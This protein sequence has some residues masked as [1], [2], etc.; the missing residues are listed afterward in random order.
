MK[1]CIIL[2]C[3]L[4]LSTRVNSR[5]SKN[6]GV[7]HNNSL[8]SN[9]EVISSLLA[10]RDLGLAHLAST[11]MT[12]KFQASNMDIAFYFKAVMGF[13]HGG[14]VVE[15]NILLDFI[16][17]SFLQPDGDVVSPGLGPG[18]KSSNGMYNQFYGYINGWLCREAMRTGRMDIHKPAW[19]FYRKFQHPL[20]GGQVTGGIFKG[21]ETDITDIFSTAN[22]GLTALE[23]GDFDAAAKA[24]KYIIRAVSLQPN[25]DEFFYLKQTTEGELITEG[26]PEEQY[27]VYYL[28]TDQPDQLWFMLGYPLVLLA[29]MGQVDNNKVC[30][31]TADKILDF[32]D[33][34]SDQRFASFWSHKIALGTSYMAAV[35]KDERYVKTSQKIV[36]E[37]MKLQD[38][39]G[40]FSYPG[41]TYRDQIDQTA[42]VSTWWSEI[43]ANLA[44][45]KYSNAQN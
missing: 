14:R 35:W 3:L 18:E 9:D 37:L 26:F 41:M 19:D 7:D 42:E 10:S 17:A 28:R 34:C 23:M 32:F 40:L 36:M 4:V 21:D 6:V 22:F 13:L 25:M 15:A 45:A 43:A 29:K 2:M 8:L 44:R 5:C 33:R 1:S 39:N 30:K 20:N 31:E 16:Q 12:D 27:K 11:I 38:Q 24:T